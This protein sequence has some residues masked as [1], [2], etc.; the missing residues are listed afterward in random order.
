MSRKS[1]WR[2]FR[3]DGLLLGG[4]AV[5]ELDAELMLRDEL[6]MRTRKLRSFSEDA[7]GRRSVCGSGCS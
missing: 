3:F 2:T 5:T 7:G 1:K 6:H 4:Q